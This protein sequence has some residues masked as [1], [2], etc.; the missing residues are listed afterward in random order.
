MKWIV[1]RHLDGSNRIIK[2]E[3]H[4]WQINIHQKFFTKV[5]L[6]IVE[7]FDDFLCRICLQNHLS[8]SGLIKCLHY[9]RNDTVNFY[10]DH[11]LNEVDE[12]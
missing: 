9:H 12:E 2:A 8:E 3:R 7:Y 10:L 6:Q 1:G 11:L 4:V 5:V